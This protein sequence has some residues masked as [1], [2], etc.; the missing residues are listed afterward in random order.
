[1]DNGIEKDLKESQR[2]AHESEE[3]FQLLF[4]KAPWGINLDQD[5]RFIEVN[6]K[7]LDTLG[8][9]REEVIGKWFGDFAL[10]LW[11]VSAN[12]SL[13]KARGKSTV[14]MRCCAKTVSV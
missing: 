11:K 13:F 6:Q 3:R 9:T 8:Y 14:S 12:A 10:N 4:N 2:V 5:G 7:W 1:M